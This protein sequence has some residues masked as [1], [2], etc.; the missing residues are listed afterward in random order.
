MLEYASW[1]YIQKAWSR[2]IENK[3]AASKPE[4]RDDGAETE[5]TRAHEKGQLPCG[6]IFFNI[7]SH[8]Q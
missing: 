7:R 8:T 3:M 6:M 4:D 2:W 5:N 1:E